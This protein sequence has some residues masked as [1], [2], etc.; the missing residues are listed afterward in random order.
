MRTAWFL[1]LIAG[2][3]RVSARAQVI[4]Y[5]DHFSARQ[6]IGEIAIVTGPVARVERAPDGTIRLSLGP[7]YR[8]RSMEV[9]IPAAF[10]ALFGD[11]R[12]FEGKGVQVRGRIGSDSTAAGLPHIALD[13]D[14]RVQVVD[15]E[16][17]TTRAAPEPEAG[18]GRSDPGAT[19]ILTVSPGYPV[20]GPSGQMRARLIEEGWTDHYCD[21]KKTTC[22]DNPLIKSPV[23]AFTGTMTRQLSGMIEAKAMFSFAPLGSAEGRKGEVDVR[24]DWSA[25]MFGGVVALTPHPMVRLGAG[26]LIGLLN[27][28]RMDDQARTAIRPGAMFEVGLRSSSARPLFLDLSASYRL[29]P[30]RS[31]GPWPGRR[32]AAVVPAGPGK[33]D[34]NFSHLSLALGL[35]WRFSS[36][37]EQ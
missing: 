14:G 31:E 32:A 16:S 12:M 24:A 29:L 11:G 8:K 18:R 9:Y 25:F 20:G 15:R 19:W 4:D 10:A 21:F 28:Q 3:P 37:T 13:E 26:P 33:L 1:F 34:A 35:G 7:S 2:V 5:V 6:H 30:T 27:S 17:V 36:G 22:H 23:F